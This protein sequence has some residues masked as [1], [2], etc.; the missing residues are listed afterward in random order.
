ML[1]SLGLAGITA[2]VLASTPANA[3]D[4]MHNDYGGHV[5]PYAARAAAAQR[6]GEPVRFGNVE[7]DS[8][9]TLLL[10][11]PKACVSP[12]SVFGFHAPWYGTPDHGVIDPK[13]TAMFARSYKPAL[14][15]VFLE[16]IRSTGGAAP[17]PLL[18]LTGA[19]LSGLGYRLCGQA[20]TAQVAAH[21][22]RVARN[23]FGPVNPYAWGEGGP[24]GFLPPG[25]GFPRPPFGW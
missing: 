15:R 21:H 11:A 14:R 6:R 7:C 20:E 12:N 4:V 18:K 17:G 13:M 19:Q 2:L 9:C 1:R 22:H 10:A 24:R 3:F 8:S 23:N 16:H 5:E 25:G